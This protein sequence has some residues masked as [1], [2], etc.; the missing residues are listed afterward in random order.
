MIKYSIF[1]PIFLLFL[2]LIY[3][4]SCNAQNK[5]PN[6]FEVVSTANNKIGI[7]KIKSSQDSNKY[8][9][10][11]CGLQDKNGNL[12]FGTS[13]QGVYKFDG[14]FYLTKWV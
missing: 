10:V 11:M 12:W 7:P 2:T 9:N 6:Q 8:N 14:K 3:F 5:A 1:K 13:D 4:S